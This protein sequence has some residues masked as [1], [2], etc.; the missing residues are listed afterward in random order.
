MKKGRFL[1]SAHRI[2]EKQKAG[3]ARNIKEKQLKNSR[4]T[5][6]KQL[7]E[8]L[9]SQ[10]DNCIFAIINP[11]VAYGFGDFFTFGSSKQSSCGAA[12]NSPQDCFLNAATV[13]K[14][15]IKFILLI[16]SEVSTSEFSFYAD[17]GSSEL[18][19]QINKIPI[20]LKN[21]VR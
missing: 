20:I 11:K 21:I 12:K 19:N 15:I 16:S 9:S 5:V 7:V 18:Q 14:E 8:L 4:N 1:W 3:K 17:F 2:T 10:R 13:L 6:L